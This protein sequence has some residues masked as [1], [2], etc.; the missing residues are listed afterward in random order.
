MVNDKRQ[1]IFVRCFTFHYTAHYMATLFVQSRKAYSKTSFI[2]CLRGS[3]K[4][5]S[6]FAWCINAC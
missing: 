1:A 4:S 2:R 6:I 5:F 3:F